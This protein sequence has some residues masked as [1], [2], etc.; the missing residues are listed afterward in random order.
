VKHRGV[1]VEIAPKNQVIVMTARG[2]FVKVP[3]TKHVQVGQEIRYSPKKE[4]LSVWQLGLAATLFLALLN[5]WP[6]LS[7]RLVPTSILPAFIIT[8][9]INPSLEM[10]ISAEQRVL[11]VDG[12]NRDGQNLASRLNVV[13]DNLGPALT[14]ITDQAEKMGY[15]KQGQNEVVV[16][17]AS[18]NNQ[19][20]K[21]LEL[22][23]SSS[24][25]GE[26]PELESVIMDAFSSRKIAQVRVW[27]VPRSLQTEAKLAGIT[28]SRYLAIQMPASPVI[29][30]RFETK[31]T[32]SDSPEVEVAANPLTRTP[33][34]EANAE[35]VRPALTPAQW[36]KETT[37]ITRRTELY[38]PNFSLAATKGDL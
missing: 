10:Q 27:Q 36:T 6:L 28:P 32:M 23:D 29:P 8:V 13:G 33:T 30:Q 1:V 37:G 12:L 16:T 35:P 14:E 15:I 24:G 22:K 18:Q 5:T 26:H 34:L 11:A 3:F 25:R 17:I 31:L 4:R 21:L 9:D 19:N 7:D 38:D 20:A 2:E